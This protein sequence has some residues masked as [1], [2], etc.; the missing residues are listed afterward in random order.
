MKKRIKK[1]RNVN[2]NKAIAKQSFGF[3]KMK[4]MLY[5]KAARF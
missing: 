4:S 5:K 1:G 2:V 3:N